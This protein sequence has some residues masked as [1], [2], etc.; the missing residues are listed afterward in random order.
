MPLNLHEGCKKHLKNQVAQALSSVKI[1]NLSFLD[2]PS[3]DEVTKLEPILPTDIKEQLEC[4]ISE[5]PLFDFIYGYLSKQLHEE[6]TFDS[7]HPEESLTF[8]DK[9]NDLQVIASEI[10]DTFDSLPWQYTFTF[11]LNSSLSSYITDEVIQITPDI[12]VLKVGD[13][14]VNNFPLASGIAIRGRSLLGGGLGSVFGS[15]GATEWEPDSVYV[16]IRAE[17]FIGKY[18]ST[19]PLNQAID[20]FKSFLGLL[21]AQRALRVRYSYSSN[22]IKSRIYIHRE[23]KTWNID[24]SSELA[25]EVGKAISDLEIDDLNGSLDTDLKKSVLISHTFNVLTKALSQQE[26]EKLRLAGR[27]LFD[28]YCGSN[29]LLSFIQATVSLEILLGDKAMSDL[30]GLGELLRN[31]CAYLIGKTHAQR[32]EV[33]SDFQNIYDIRSKIVHRGKSQLS[34]RDRELFHKLQWMA[35]RVIQEEIELMGKN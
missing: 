34:R 16:Q 9:Y 28:S 26:S 12:R 5:S 18:V 2:Y 14:L 20:T 1:K 4:Y 3:F 7:E 22:T 32:E 24:D 10:I 19:S 21:I 6:Q 17:G 30:M 15:A 27:W 31:R 25:S 35:N 29:E 11:K 13:E 23:T 8:I 33:L